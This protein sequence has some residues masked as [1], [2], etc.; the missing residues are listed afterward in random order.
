M[1]RTREGYAVK[2]YYTVTPELAIGYG[3]PTKPEYLGTIHHTK[4]GVAVG[5]NHDYYSTGALRKYLTGQTEPNYPMPAIRL[6]VT[7]DYEFIAIWEIGKR[8]VYYHDDYE[9]VTG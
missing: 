4:H 6:G 2:R 3:A 8:C 1:L 7:I 5:V 9:T